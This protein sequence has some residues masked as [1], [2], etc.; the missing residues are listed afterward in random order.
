MYLAI[1]IANLYRQQNK[2]RVNPLMKNV[3]ANH[4]PAGHMYFTNFYLVAQWHL[5]YLATLEKIRRE[6]TT[7]LYQQL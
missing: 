4:Y 3:W 7:H 5:A 1:Q 6:N 2:V